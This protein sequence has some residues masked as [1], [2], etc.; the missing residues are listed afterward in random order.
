MLIL[1]GGARL[2]G[3]ATFVPDPLPPILSSIEYLLVAGGGS[4]GG[5]AGGERG[6]GKP[7]S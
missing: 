7:I 5:G 6:G 4:G 3:G 1:T 2:S